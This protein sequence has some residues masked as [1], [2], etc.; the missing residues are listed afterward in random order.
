MNNNSNYYA[1][2]ICT[3]EMFFTRT[4]L[5]RSSMKVASKISSKWRRQNNGLKMFIFQ[6]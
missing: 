6:T 3:F 1:M 4:E 2:T 5:R